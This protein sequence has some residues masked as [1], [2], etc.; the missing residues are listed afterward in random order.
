MK[1]FLCSAILITLLLVGGEELADKTNLTLIAQAQSAGEPEPPRVLID[2]TYPP[3]AARTINVPSGSNLQTALNQALPGDEIVLQAGAT[4]L[5]PGDGFMLPAKSNASNQWIIIRSSNLAGLPAAGTRVAPSNAASMPKILS[6]NTGAALATQTGTGAASVAYWRV[7]GIEFS[8]TTT[9]LP[10]ANLAGAAGNTGLVRLGDPY[11]TNPSN[12]PHDIVIDR[13]YI[14]GR[15]TMNTIRGVNLNSKAAAVIDSYLSDFH[16]VQWESQAICGWN[17]P[18]PFKIVNNYLEGATENVMF[19]GSDPKISGLIPSDI[20][21]RRNYF[22][23]PLSWK[24]GSA[25]YAGYHWSVK[26]LLELKNAQRLLI[27]GNRFENNWADAQ[28][29]YGLL[30]KSVNQ[31]GTAPWCTSQDID[32]K[33]NIVRHMG[34]A[35]N[36]QGRDTNNLSGQTKRIRIKNNLFDDVSQ[37]VWNG[38]GAFIK[39]TDTLNVIVDHNT[40][41]Q[42]G[43]IITV[44]GAAITGFVFT[45]N[46]A[47]HNVYGIKGDGTSA[48]NSTLNTYFPAC[49]FRRNEIVGG[50]I[51]QY[52]GDNF[53]LALLDLVGFVDRANGNYRLLATSPCKNAGTDGRDLGADID[54]IEAAMS[55][56]AQPSNSPPQVSV[57]ASPLSGAAPLTV[58][59]ASAAFDPDGQVV[60]YIWNFGDGQTSSQASPSHL[61]QSAGTFTAQLTVTDNLGATAIASVVITAANPPPPTGSADVVLYASEATVRSANWQVV[62]DSSAAGGAR[63][64]NVD[65]GAPK[66]I[67]ALASPANYFEIPFNAQAGR[68]YRLWIRGKAKNDYWGNDSVFVQFSGS[69]NSSGG[70]IYRIGTTAATE[71]NLEDCSGCG[72]RGWGWQDNGWGVGVM[73]P[74]IYFQTTGAQTIRV[75]VRE[76]GLS[77]DQIV[78]SPATYLNASPGALKNDIVILPR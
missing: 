32:F 48:G 54:A 76:D 22:F 46:I 9:A 75:Q 5:A 70:A 21:M 25:G 15:P 12:V 7:V 23:K 24:A 29:G 38:D 10:D 28:T 8:V 27:E 44:Y 4:Y 39:V 71:Y 1:R 60:A 18:G 72:L 26:N 77:I 53:F 30:F 2:T 36:I 78:L 16:G 14:H 59:F 66:L 3:P 34:A 41:L 52:P 74:L 57:T 47:P 61:Y 35:I 62:A 63:L 40:V 49:V 20:E 19:G 43:N 33:N 45:N 65:F 13:C 11:E 50:P 67:G 68:A 17:G 56:A 64:S 37:P 58:A 6:Q 55:G 69:V 31:D 51:L 42:T 73:G